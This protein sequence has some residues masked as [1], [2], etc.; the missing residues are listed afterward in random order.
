[1]YYMTGAVGLAL[2][3]ST[4]LLQRYGASGPAE[5]GHRLSVRHRDFR[6][7]VARAIPLEPIQSATYAQA[8]D[9][10]VCDSNLSKTVYYRHGMRFLH[11]RPIPC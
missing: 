8:H 9:R 4:A 10:V 2:V 3:G 1:M 6:D 7:A 11:I 5:V